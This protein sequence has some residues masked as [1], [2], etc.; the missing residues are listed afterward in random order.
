MI[1]SIPTIN[2]ARL[3]LRAMRL[4]DFDRYCEIFTIF[5]SPSPIAKA[6]CGG[7]NT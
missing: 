1:R 2:T 4:E 7:S 3:A 6:T 5:L